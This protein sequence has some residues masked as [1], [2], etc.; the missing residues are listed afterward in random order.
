MKSLKGYTPGLARLF[1]TTPAA[2]YERQRALVRAGM[3]DVGEGRGPGSGVRTTAGSVALLIIT[4]L[5][6]DSLSETEERTRQ[7]ADA[8]PVSDDGRCPVTGMKTFLDALS[9]IL[10]SKARASRVQEINVSRTAARAR[11]TFRGGPTVEFAGLRSVEPRLHVSA[12][13]AREAFQAIA[14]D[15]YAML[16]EAT[17]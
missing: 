9:S 14:Q 8:S 7:I 15:V 11:I 17:Q 10:S 6:T 16:E 1:G 3:L 13:L 4:V 2:L 12:G 5:A